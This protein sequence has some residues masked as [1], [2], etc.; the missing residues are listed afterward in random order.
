MFATHMNR[1]HAELT[2]HTSYDETNAHTHNNGTEQGI[3]H[4]VFSVSSKYVWYCTVA[5][6]HSV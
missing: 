1:L 3:Q 6:G 4:H 5:Y 2:V